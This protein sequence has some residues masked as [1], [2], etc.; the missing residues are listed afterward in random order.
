MFE[1][2][3]KYIDEADKIYIVGHVGPD[4]DAVGASFGM[5]N[6]LKKIG[7]NAK[8][9][10]PACSDTFKFLPGINEAV[11]NVEESEYDLLIAVD[12]SDKTRLAISKEDF[13]KAKHVIVLDHHMANEPYGDFNYINS[14]LPAASE[15]I[16]NFISY[17]NNEIDKVIAT[18]LYLGIMTDTGSFNY[19]STKPSTLIVAANLVA[20]GIDFS[21]I[22]KKVNDTIKESKLKLIAKAI[23]NM[24][25]YYDGRLRYTYVDQKVMKA[26]GINDE[27]A[28]GMTNYLRMVDG[29]EVAIYV[30]EK[31]DGSN[32]VSMRSNELIDISKIAIANGGG[33]HKR[34]AGF[35][36]Q[37]PYE[38]AKNELIN[39]VGVMLGDTSTTN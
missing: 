20:T 35:T 6:A 25:V 13:E 2:A 3:K 19:S 21:Y 11:E 23:D 18:Y 8:V 16:Y 36:M 12:S 1:E 33:G 15:I 24:E 29:T 37:K 22:C 14:D 17:L 30:R 38:E 5:Y 26:L 28:E 7:K 32:K 10:M 9:I 34:A 39:V 31:S 27:E 4:G